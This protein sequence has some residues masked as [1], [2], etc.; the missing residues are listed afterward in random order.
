MIQAL[1]WFKLLFCENNFTF[2]VICAEEHVVLHYSSQHC[3][4]PKHKNTLFSYFMRILHPYQCAI[5][6]IWNTQNLYRHIL[7]APTANGSYELLTLGWAIG[8]CGFS[9]PWRK[10]LIV[11]LSAASRSSSSSLMMHSG[12]WTYSIGMSSSSSAKLFTYLIL[13]LNFELI[14]GFVMARNVLMNHDGW[15][16][17]KDFKFFLSLLSIIW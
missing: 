12:M 5:I 2:E 9:L 3:E 14:N 8:S 6:T 11:E 17:M 7:L 1:R 16:M 10:L 13:L 15:T 4:I